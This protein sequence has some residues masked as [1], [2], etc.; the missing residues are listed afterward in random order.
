MG[1]AQSNNISDAV[2]TVS[3]YISNSTTANTH[4]VDNIQNNATFKDCSIGGDVNVTTISEIVQSARQIVAAKQSSNLK[5]DVQQQALQTASS[6]VG[7]MGVGFADANNVASQLV[8][9]TTN[10]INSVTASASEMQSIHNNVVC[11]RSHIG[12]SVNINFSTKSK[13][14][15]TQSLNNQQVAKVVTSVSQSITQKATAKVAGITGFLIAIALIIAAFGYAIAKPLAT[16][17]GKILLIGIMLFVFGAILVA[18][19]LAKSPPFFDENLVCKAG[20]FGCDSDACVKKSQ[21][22][23][24]LKH[25]PLRYNYAIVNASGDRGELLPMVISRAAASKTKMGYNGGYNGTQYSNFEDNKATGKW[26]ADTSYKIAQVPQLPNPL[27]MQSS[28]GKYGRIPDAYTPGGV[29]SPGVAEYGKYGKSTTNPQCTMQTQK[30]AATTTDLSLAIASL[31]DTAWNNYMNG[32]DTGDDISDDQKKARILHAR[33]VL[34]RALEIDCTYYVNP[35]EEVSVV[36]KATGLSTVGKAS[37]NLDVSYQFT[38]KASIAS[39][40]HASSGGGH[41]KGLFGVCNSRDYKFRWFMKYFGSWILGLIFIA[42]CL[43]IV[44]HHRSAAKN[45]SRK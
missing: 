36:D 16:G 37:D 39:Y 40:Q 3:D 34:C 11:D 26:I 9:S 21:Q 14:Y 31:N 4:E 23:K 17:S 20:G 12:G 19:F 33:F 35:N 43:F 42:L 27:M 29:C 6:T 24:I 41:V 45:A 10:I 28:N 7:S 30:D 25:T 32:T 15:S 18:M 44:F 1:A 38:P 2:T 8:N 13:F 5:N 22:T